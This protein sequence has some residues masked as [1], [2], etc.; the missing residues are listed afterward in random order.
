MKRT[1]LCKGMQR[2]GCILMVL[3]TCCCVGVA[4]DVY[5]GDMIDRALLSPGNT[6]RLHRALDKARAGE[7]VSIVYLGG[8][9]TEGTGA[10]PAATRC[11]AYL[12]AQGFAE[13]YMTSRTQLKYFNSGIGGT[14][15][16]MGLARCEQDVFAHR[17][18]IV[19]VEYAVNDG[20]DAASAM[21]YESLVRKI[22]NSPTEPAVIL[23]FMLTKEGNSAQEHMQKIGEYYDLGMISIRDAIQYQLDAGQMRWLDYSMDTVHPTNKGHAFIAEVIGRYFEVAEAV[24]PQSYHVPLLGQYGTTFEGIKDLKHKDEKIQSA[25]SF[26]YGECVC[27][28]FKTGWRHLG[29]KGGASP[30][31]FR[32]NA[33]SMLI[34]YKQEPNEEMGMAEV[35]VDGQY[36]TM[37]NGYSAHAW[38]NPVI[39]SVLLGGRGEHTVEIRI[40]EGAE[41]KNFY[42]F[43]IGYVP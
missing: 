6:E 8:S 15:S 34:T 26:P 10:H 17:P 1:F 25:G 37:L 7:T 30:F 2:V 36:R 13:K 18:D 28:T 33:T 40:P 12:S 3:L 20:V 22:L 5:T 4:E 21:Y 24:P 32:I 43:N 39:A 29:E 23:L 14:P 41:N 42:I 19:F 11:Y 9:I 31:V 16:V 35:W 38:G 27:Y